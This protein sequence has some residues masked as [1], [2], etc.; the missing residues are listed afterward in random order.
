MRRYIE[1]LARC[2]TRIDGKYYD[3]AKRCSAGENEVYVLYSLAGGQQLSQKAI[4]DEWHI[5]KTTINYAVNRLKREGF[6]QV[7]AADGREKLLALTPQGAEYA[8]NALKDMLEAEKC[9]MKKTLEKYSPQFIDAL[10]FF[11]RHIMEYDGHD[12]K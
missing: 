7:T 8:E 1:R 4:A 2:I 12:G 5:P 10:E 3:L 11:A 6:I 9:A